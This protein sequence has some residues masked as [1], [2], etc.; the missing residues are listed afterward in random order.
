MNFANHNV[1]GF[2]DTRLRSVLAMDNGVVHL[3]TALHIVGLDGEEFL[4]RVSG[5][6]SALLIS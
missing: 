1:E 2:G 6:V 3:R 4:Q 5:T